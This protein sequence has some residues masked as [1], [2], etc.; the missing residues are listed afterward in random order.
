MSAIKRSD[1]SPCCETPRPRGTMASASNVKNRREEVDDEKNRRDDQALRA[2]VEFKMLKLLDGTIFVSLVCALVVIDV[3]FTIKEPKDPR[4]R[5]FQGFFTGLLILEFMARS[6]CHYVLYSLSRFLRTPFSLLDI[7]T[8]FTDI[9]IFVAVS[10]SAD[11]NSSA[12]AINIIRF[13]RALKAVDWFLVI[14]R[15]R[16]SACCIAVLGSTL[17]TSSEDAIDEA[18][19]AQLD[20]MKKRGIFLPSEIVEV[21]NSRDIAYSQAAPDEKT[22]K[23]SLPPHL[24]TKGKRD[25]LWRYAIVVGVNPDETYTIKYQGNGAYWSKCPKGKMRRDFRLPSAVNLGPQGLDKDHPNFTNVGSAVSERVPPLLLLLESKTWSV[26]VAIVVVIQFILIVSGALSVGGSS[27]L[28]II[29]A[30][31]FFVEVGCRIA[32]FCSLKSNAL[33]CLKSPITVGDSLLVFTDI[34]YVVIEFVNA[35]AVGD[36]SCIIK[37]CRIIRMAQFFVHLLPKKSQRALT[38][39]RNMQM[40]ESA[41]LENP[42]SN[43]SP[44]T[45]EVKKTM[46]T[47]VVTFTGVRGVRFADGCVYQGDWVDGLEEGIGQLSFPN[48]DKYK[49][50]FKGGMKH[51][52]GLFVFANGDQFRG[53][54]FKNEKHGLG[55]YLWA[56]GDRFEATFQHGKENGKCTFF[57]ADDRVVVYYFNNGTEVP[58]PQEFNVEQKMA[59]MN[60]KGLNFRE[61]LVTGEGNGEV[62][63]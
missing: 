32:L 9:V 7:F 10:Q 34:A 6:Y 30:F 48:G 13:S 51:G 55:T 59:A 5:S 21:V 58:P 19:K 15:I 50:G 39:D 33:L 26:F 3:V 61:I 47:D 12:R 31:V 41:D 52:R 40:E 46:T 54:F 43:A 24:S 63:L 53:S 23:A 14:R 4:V 49:G 37:L 38:S 44:M 62:Q 20:D 57:S 16:N 36:I 45:E 18:E 27:L 28:S 25:V 1:Q 35:H 2:S 22:S 56:D 29:L 8:I 11:A 60:F 42:E 17:D